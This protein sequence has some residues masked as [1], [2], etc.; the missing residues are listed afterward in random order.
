MRKLKNTNKT[1]NKINNINS[2]TKRRDNSG[3][4]LGLFAVLFIMVVGRAF[5]VG[6]APVI[7]M[8]GLNNSGRP[9][10]L[11]FSDVL[12]RA[13]DIQT[14]EIRG[15]NA[16]GVLKDGTKYT[17]TIT[18][19]PNNYRIILYLV[20]YSWSAWWRGR[21]LGTQLGQSKPN[22]NHN[23]KTGNNIQRCGRY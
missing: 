18:Y 11:N 9:M 12:R 6:G 19:D 8:S 5:L 2:K 14:M 23:R 4:F 7:G 13:D 3:W 16:H 22:K 10:V 20:D 1:Q 17:A 21:W 15:N